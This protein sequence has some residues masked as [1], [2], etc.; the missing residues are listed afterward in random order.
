M[1]S[2]FFA[3]SPHLGGKKS[4]ILVSVFHR[5]TVLAKNFISTTL[6]AFRITDFCQLNW[7]A[8]RFNFYNNNHMVSFS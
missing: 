2:R 8:F 6:Q 3:T 7:L 4:P 5:L 1:E